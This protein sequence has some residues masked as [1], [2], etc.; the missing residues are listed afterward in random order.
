MNNHKKNSI[1]INTKVGSSMI[2]LLWI[3]FIGSALTHNLTISSRPEWLSWFYLGNVVV[4]AV[5]AL[6]MRKD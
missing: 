5:L 1:E 6:F 4:T 3:L 2:A